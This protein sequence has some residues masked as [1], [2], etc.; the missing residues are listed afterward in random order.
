MHYRLNALLLGN[1]FT[2]S[3]Y[4]L[5]FA[6]F[7]FIIIVEQAYWAGDLLKKGLLERKR[8]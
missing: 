1:N 2:S 4:E 8:A 3:Y 5:G 7:L 6:L